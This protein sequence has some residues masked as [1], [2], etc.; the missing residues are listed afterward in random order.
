MWNWYKSM[1]TKRPLWTK[2]STSCVLMT[3][4]DVG[5]QAMERS[6]NKEL[7][8]TRGPD[9]NLQAGCPTNVNASL[10]YSKKN[11]QLLEYDWSRTLQVG[12]T[13]LTYSGP[14]SHVWYGL[15]ERLV[16]TRHYYGGLVLRMTLDALLFS[17]MA[18]A[19]YFSWRGILEGKSMTE[20]QEKLA[21]KWQHAVVASWSFW[22]A[23]N[24]M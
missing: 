10:D 17:P 21:T 14:I 3:V 13:G 22:P 1:L 23:A 8:A 16:T 2:A 15:L 9:I 6:M 18:V 24:I 7:V 12:I 20:L 11:Q 4:S 19:G 5:C